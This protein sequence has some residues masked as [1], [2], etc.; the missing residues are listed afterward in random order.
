MSQHSVIIVRHCK[1]QDHAPGAD[2]KRQ[3]TEAG[4]QQAR[5]LGAKMKDALANVD[6]AFLS[7]ATRAQQTWLELATGAG[8]DTSEVTVHLEPAIYTG[9]PTKI[10]EAVLAGSDGKTS[11]V[12][13]H[14]PTI[15]EVANRLLKKEVNSPTAYGMLTGMG[16][17]VECDL[18]WDQWSPGCANLAG[19]KWVD[20]D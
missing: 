1:A 18:D 8:I 15:S 11:I 10:I 13:G 12:V 20:I 4:K 2:E 6:C 9:G 7:P 3:L 17:V 14:E 5:A 19:F 16:V